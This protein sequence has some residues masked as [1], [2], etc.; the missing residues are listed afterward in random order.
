MDDDRVEKLFEEISERRYKIKSKIID[1][2][3]KFGKC[4][5]EDFSPV[6]YSEDEDLV[7]F[8]YI[9]EWYR[10]IEDIIEK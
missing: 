3:N 8:Q 7:L 6:K 10:Y 1:L 5:I 9:K 4:A 2:L